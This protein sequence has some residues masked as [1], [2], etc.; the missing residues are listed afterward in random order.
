MVQAPSPLATGTEGEKRKE[1]D[2]QNAANARRKSAA[3]AFGIVGLLAVAGV[4]VGLLVSRRRRLRREQHGQD[5]ALDEEG[6]M[7][8]GA[9]GDSTPG[10]VAVL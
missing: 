5:L 9:A 8:R 1:H 4:G 7:R 10:S 3:L 6:G 2:R